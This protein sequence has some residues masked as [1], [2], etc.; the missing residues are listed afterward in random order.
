ML[1]TEKAYNGTTSL[2]SPFFEGSVAPAISN[3][4][5]EICDSFTKG[6]LRFWVVASVMPPNDI[7]VVY[8]DGEAA[9]QIVDIHD[10]TEIELSLEDGPH[11]VEFSYQ[12][13]IFGVTPLPGLTRRQ[14]EYF[15]S[16]F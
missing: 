13:N 10:W 4:T 1:S 9:A 16:T 5:L 2:K 7:F 14:G 8:I 6:V 12:Y 15:Y 3:A 11:K